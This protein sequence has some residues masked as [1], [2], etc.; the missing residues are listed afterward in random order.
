MKNANTRY[1]FSGGK[2]VVEE[3]GSTDDAKTNVTMGTAIALI[4]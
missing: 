1:L 2:N 3:A 4:P